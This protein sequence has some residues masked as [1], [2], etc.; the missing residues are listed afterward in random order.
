MVDR[1]N[2]FYRQNAQAGS[3]TTF[4]L[5]SYYYPTTLYQLEYQNTRRLILALA[6]DNSRSYKKRYFDEFIAV[7]SLA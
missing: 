5:L 3:C 4:L 6:Y 7:K 2:A 1:L